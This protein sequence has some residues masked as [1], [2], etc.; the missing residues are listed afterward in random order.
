[1]G[2]LGSQS[3]VNLAQAAGLLSSSFLRAWSIPS[4]LIPKVWWETGSAL[5]SL[6]SGFCSGQS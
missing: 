6:D 1:M 4:D 5:G 3:F 2:G